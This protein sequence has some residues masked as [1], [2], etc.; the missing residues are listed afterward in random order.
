MKKH[1][2]MFIAIM[3][4]FVMTF[5]H[6]CTMIEKE[7]GKEEKEKVTLRW[8][9]YGQKFKSSDTVI[10][11][12]ND[13][14][15]KKFPN[16][17]IEFE[18]VSIE[19]YKEK[20]NLAMAANEPLDIVWIG[21][22]IF[23][24]SEEVKK[25]SFMALDYLLS[26][27]GNQLMEEIPATMWDKQKRDGKIYGIPLEG[28]LFRKQYAL[29]TTKRDLDSYGKADEIHKIN[30]QS[31]Y[32]DEEAYKSFE[33]YLKFLKEEQRMGTGVSCDTFSNLP[34]KGLEGIYG[35]NSPYVIK[36]FDSELK[37]YNKYR[38]DSYREYY[39][40][41]SRWYEE[42]YIREDVEEVLAPEKLN[43]T[44][45]GNSVFLDETGVALD[46]IATEYEKASIPLQDYSYIAYESGRNVLAIPRTTEH[47]QEAVEVIEYLNSK[48]GAELCKLLSN[49]TIGRHYVKKN[50][51]TIDKVV[52]NNGKEL[53]GLSPY[54]VANLFQNYERIQGEFEE[55]KKENEEAVVSPL[56]GFE[57][58]TRMII[59]EMEKVD[60]IVS[61]YVK[62]LEKGTYENW[63][64]EYNEMLK[65]MEGVGD[66]KII[67]EIQKQLDVFSSN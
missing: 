44:T 28:T 29:V 42:G 63:E 31:L 60:L 62:H 26:T 36:I 24:Y 15:Q 20:W 54:V 5:L 35:P 25:G 65:K 57:L 22:D 47:P 30:I 41:V 2:N 37:V 21:N 19:N 12:F 9:V 8:M 61:E 38:L 43:G 49:G 64:E 6:G 27:S 39:E 11:E 58:D 56:T 40:I 33:D 4:I 23:N 13:R 10:A 53:Y 7:E 17:T 46:A 34:A 67:N 55:I 66:E 59:L 32:G 14:I 52:D 16:V 1:K 3:L 18:I 50:N 51:H 45:T 48:E